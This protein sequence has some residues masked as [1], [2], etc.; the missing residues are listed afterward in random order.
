LHIIAHTPFKTITELYDGQII[1][2]DLIRP[3]SEMLLLVRKKRNKYLAQKV[4]MAGHL[5]PV[6]PRTG[7]D[8]RSFDEDKD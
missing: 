5:S 8:P 7:S 3:A 1:D 6:L 4:D 2:V